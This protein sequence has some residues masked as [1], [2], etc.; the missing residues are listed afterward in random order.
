LRVL[1]IAST[2]PR[3]VT[4]APLARLS[5]PVTPGRRQ[6]AITEVPCLVE[7]W[8]RELTD[9]AI[10]RGVFFSVPDLIAAIR[11]YLDAHNEDPRPFVWTAP[12]DSLLEKVGRCK[13]VLETVH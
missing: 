6:R 1:R 11:R 2:P 9:K 10:R 5:R 3:S 12:T 7:R 4:S 8:F 13:A